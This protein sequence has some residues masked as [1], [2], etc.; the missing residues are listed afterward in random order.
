MFTFTITSI[1]QYVLL[2]FKIASECQLFS[3]L[4]SLLQDNYNT[5][6]LGILHARED[7]IRNLLARKIDITVP[8]GVGVLFHFFYLLFVLFKLNFVLISYE[9]K[10][11]FIWLRREREERERQ[12]QNCCS[13]P[14][15]KICAQPKMTLVQLFKCN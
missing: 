6:H 7:V 15:L 1:T 12:F 8:A 11:F 14:V 2:D 5:F 9:V 4:I 3:F 13:L 10:M